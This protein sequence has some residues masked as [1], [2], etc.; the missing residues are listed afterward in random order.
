VETRFGDDID[1]VLT[2][3]AQEWPT[4]ILQLISDLIGGDHAPKLMQQGNIDFQITR[5]LLGVSM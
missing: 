1:L 4:Q 3:A 2:G 5:G